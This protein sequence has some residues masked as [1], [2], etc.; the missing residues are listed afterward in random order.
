M[1]NIDKSEKLCHPLE[2]KFV[3]VLSYHN[4]PCQMNI[5]LVKE[6]NNNDLII[7]DHLLIKVQLHS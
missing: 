5:I 7:E 2:R 3:S 4:V 1:S 6:D